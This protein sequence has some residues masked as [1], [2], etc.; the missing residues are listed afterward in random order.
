MFGKV[1]DN[2]YY[3]IANRVIPREDGRE[4]VRVS[5][6]DA[7]KI[8]NGEENSGIKA[9][10][11]PYVSFSFD[12]DRSYERTGYLEFQ[13]QA[14]GYIEVETTPQQNERRSLEG[15]KIFINVLPDFMDPNILSNPYI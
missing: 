14:S 1:T 9:L 15:K 6:D 2:Y 5:E 4:I 3:G 7:W 10:D 13:E 11:T 12:S 8:L